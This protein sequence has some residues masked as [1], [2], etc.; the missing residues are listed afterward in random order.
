MTKSVGD[1]SPVNPQNFYSE[2]QLHNLVPLWQ[3]LHKLV[4]K[5]PVTPVLPVHWS[6]T[7][8][9]RSYLLRAGEV[10]TTDQA[11]RRVLILENPGLPGRASIT[12]SL[13]AGLQLIKPGEL[14]RSHRHSQSALRFVVEGAGAYTSV[15]GERISMSP[16]DLI[17]TPSLRWH[18]HGNESTLPTVWLDGLD[19]PIVE[20]FD[21]GFAETSSTHPQSAGRPSGGNGARFGNN[22]M[23]VNWRPTDRSSPVLKYP[24]ERS[25]ETL[26]ALARDGAPDEW[27]GYKMRFINPASGGAPMPSIATF[28]QLL[29][30]G[31]TTA[32]YRSTDSTVFVV[33]KGEGETVV[34]QS[35][36]AWGPWDIF[37]VPSWS[38]VMHRCRREAHLFSFSDRSVQELLG[39]WREDLNF[40]GAMA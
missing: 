37:V 35:T 8:S 23:P 9:L 1:D 32:A 18:D 40:A 16:G 20:F 11:E 29:P 34:G 39:I 19:I 30:E 13:Y 38:P 25:C 22:M 31:L 24:Y 26:E 3:Q 36:F 28:I 2:I 7:K 5:V 10:V 15:D 33:I 6:Y 17:L 21:A 27:H 4:P 12:H 14:A